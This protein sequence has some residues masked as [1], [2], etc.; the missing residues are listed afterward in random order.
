MTIIILKDNGDGTL[1]GADPDGV[2]YDGTRHDV[3]H[4]ELTVETTLTDDGFNRT[5]SWRGQVLSTGYLNKQTF[6]D[7]CTLQAQNQY[8]RCTAVG[9]PTGT[10]EEILAGLWDDEVNID[11][12]TKAFYD[13]PPGMDPVEKTYPLIDWVARSTGKKG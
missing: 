9:K 6:I 8:D 10:V 3:G 2:L 5:T 11:T 12:H 7:G 1:L 13:M 4:D